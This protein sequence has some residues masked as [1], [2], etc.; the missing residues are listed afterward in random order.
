MAQSTWQGVSRYRENRAMS[1]RD[2]LDG[3]GIA[4]ESFD[5]L[6]PMDSEYDQVAFCFVCVLE[7]LFSGPTGACQ[8]TRFREMIALLIEF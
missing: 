8:G 5:R 6:S 1:G 7:D 2:Q 3:D 4:I